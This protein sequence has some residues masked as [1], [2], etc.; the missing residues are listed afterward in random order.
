MQHIMVD[1]EQFRVLPK[2][3]LT[4]DGNPLRKDDKC[5]IDR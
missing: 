5:S 3:N 2:H 1:T 4:N